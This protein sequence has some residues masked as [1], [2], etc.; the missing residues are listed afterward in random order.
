MNSEHTSTAS[1]LSFTLSGELF[2]IH[3]NYVIKILEMTSFTKI[4]QGPP[5]LLGVTNLTGSVLPV[6]DTYLK[7]GFKT[8][9]KK[10]TVIIVL[11]I[12]LNGKTTGVGITADIVNEVFEITQSDIKPYP[13]MG[14]KYNTEYI[15]GVITRNNRFVLLLDVEKLFADDEINDFVEAGL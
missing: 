7:F 13:A 6:I 3:V 8:K 1:Y 5:Y 9:E 4:P 14:S 2:A 10:Q 12:N 15:K 11:N